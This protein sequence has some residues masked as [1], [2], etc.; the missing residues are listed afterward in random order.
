MLKLI[1][2]AVRG[3]VIDVQVKRAILLVDKGIHDIAIVIT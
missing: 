1:G 2:N 3:W